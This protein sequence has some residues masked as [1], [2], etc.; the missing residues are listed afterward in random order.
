MRTLF[1]CKNLISH[2]LRMSSGSPP[3]L[4]SLGGPHPFD[5]LRGGSPCPN[6]F[7]FY[8]QR[9]ST[10]KPQFFVIDDRGLSMVWLR[11]IRILGY[12]ILSYLIL[13]YLILSH[14]TSHM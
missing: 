7:V 9:Q 4:A 12:L 11:L 5:M 10:L 14:V 6:Y 2:P 8:H 13:S 3:S 1:W